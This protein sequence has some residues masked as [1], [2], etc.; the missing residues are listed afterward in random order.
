MQIISTNKLKYWTLITHFFI[1]V[2]FGHGILFFGLIEVFAIPN[3]NKIHINFH[4]PTLFENRLLLVALSSIIGQLFIAAS[5][6]FKNRKIT[7]HIAG[8]IFLWITIIIFTLHNAEDGAVYFATITALPFAICTL[9]PFI[10][11]TIKN[12]YKKLRHAI[13]DL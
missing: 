1:I 13:I 11:E 10:G 5:I 8:L 4:S 2:G 6:Y 9:I 12:L 7:T 3:L